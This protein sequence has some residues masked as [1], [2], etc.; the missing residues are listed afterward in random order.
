MRAVSQQSGPKIL[1]IGVV[2]DAKVV[3][4]RLIKQRSHVTIGPSEKAMFVV[5]TRK[6][7]PNFR[8][9]ELIGNDYYL[10]FLD[11]MSGRVALKTGISELSELKAQA[12]QIT[13]GGVTFNRIRLTEDSRG[14]VVVGETTFLF[15]FVVPP[16]AQ[17]RPQLPVSVQKGMAGDIDWFT[18]IVA[19]F[20]FL[21]HFFL[22]ALVY[23][24]WMDPVVDDEYAMARLI[25]STKSLPPPPPLEKPVAEVETENTAAAATDDKPA[26]KPSGGGGSGKAAGAGAGKGAGKGDTAEADAKAAEIASALAELDVQTLGALGSGGVATDGVLGSSDVPAGLLDDAAASSMGAGTGEPGG[27]KGLGGSGTGSVKPGAGGG[28]GKLSDIGAT[29][30]SGGGQG[31][32]GAGTAKKV[33]GPKGSAIVGGAGVAGGSVANAS[34]V[35]ARMRGRF[36]NCYQTGLNSNPELQGSVTLVAKIGPNGEVRGVSGGGGGLGSIVPCLKAVVASG[37]FSP[38]DGGGATV[39]IPIT[40]VKQ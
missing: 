28:A 7:P 12:K 29:G 11:G 22:V 33:E 16:P 18:T 13:A 32:T 25:E 30:A 26:A 35:V 19:S 24:D 8:L 3:D 6:I 40:F 17:P 1:R 31:A 27:L 34:S 4:E 2:Q 10:N 14:K 36:R 39:T 9:F 23:S 15:Q 5:P 20:S 37:G 21:L 38:P